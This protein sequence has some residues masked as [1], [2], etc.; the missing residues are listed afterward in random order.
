MD[1][2]HYH[3]ILDQ[4]RGLT[5]TSQNPLKAEACCPSH[6]DHKPSL[7]IGVGADGKLLLNCHGNSGCTT[8]TILKAI[9]RTFGDLYPDHLRK[10]GK[11]TGHRTNANGKRGVGNTNGTTHRPEPGD[12]RGQDAEGSPTIRPG[13]PEDKTSSHAIP[14]DSDQSVAP[15]TASAGASRGPRKRDKVVAIYSYHDLSGALRM[16]VVKFDPKSFRQRR[17]L[18]NGKWDWKSVPAEERI[19]YRWPE[20]VAATTAPAG[21]PN[22]PVFICEGEKDADRLRASGLTATTNPGGA[23]TKSSDRKWLPQYNEALRG[24]HC[25]IIPDQD[26]PDKTAGRITGHVHAATVANELLP[27]A[28]SVR[29]LHLPTLP[30]LD[31]SKKWDVS[32]WLD[33]GGT[34]D[35]FFSALD[36][37]PQW[38]HQD[39]IP[40][41]TAPVEAEDD[42]YRL[43]RLYAHR[44]KHPDGLTI[45]FWADAW[46]KWENNRYRLIETS[47]LKARVAGHIKEV[48]DAK[49]IADQKANRDAEPPKSKRVTCGTVANALLALSAITVLP[50]NTDQPSWIG[51]IPEPV[52]VAEPAGVGSQ[53][54][55]QA[56]ATD[57]PAPL[58]IIIPA[59]AQPRL[60]DGRS[61][62]Y[63]AAGNGIL[64]IDHYVDT[65]NGI[66]L[67]H[68]PNFFSLSSIEYPFDAAA[69]CP[70]WLRFVDRVFRGDSERINMLQEWM[71]LCLT[72]DT[73][74]QRFL[75]MH[76]EGSNGKSV[77]C[78]ALTALLGDI[79]VSNLSLDQLAGEFGLIQMQ[80]KLVNIVAEIAEMER[81]HEGHLKQLSSGDRI[82]CN[83]KNKSH[84]SM[85]PTCRLMFATN[86]LPK[87]SDKSEG[88]W[89]RILFLSFTETIQSH[90]KI[91]N[92]DKA[93][94]WRAK[95]ELP[96]ML[97]WALEGL[98]RLR[99]TGEFTFSAEGEWNKQEYRN[100]SNPARMFLMEILMPSPTGQVISSELYQ[101]YRNWC[102]QHNHRPLASNVFAKEVKRLFPMA[103]SVR[104]N[105]DY[106]VDN[107]IVSKRVMGYVGVSKTADSEIAIPQPIY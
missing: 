101:G 67:P 54:E 2:S 53:S 71:G 106:S 32:D 97:N 55:A 27:F 83:R 42:P 16:Q 17:P 92:M 94:W 100:E 23:T 13:D 38:T 51:P 95:G 10:D 46:W 36:A 107:S 19:L 43:A 14:P 48:F 70:T 15:S 11:G 37:C 31:V 56:T 8:A 7:S 63:L 44:D 81:V 59:H 41:P 91:H 3:R 103:E 79:N 28:A 90:E 39:T 66:L 72:A 5:V 75:I 24:L 80:G 6:D 68:T 104:L 99:T 96:G 47:E 30:K 85:L 84:L 102:D 20:F 87:F 65:G 61:R 74:Y 64:N 9:G 4:L 98:K 73:S 50:C 45:R 82:T 58:P 93:A 88:I 86:T 49:N 52:G 1:S 26:L 105:V 89:R 34:R 62:S 12:V 21:D 77:V 35:Q 76:G 78:G 40:E 25:V 69:T 60:L 18:P 22:R 29:V 57:T 33:A